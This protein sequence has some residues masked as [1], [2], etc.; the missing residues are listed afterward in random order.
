[1]YFYTMLLRLFSNYFYDFLTDTYWYFIILKKPK[2]KPV[3]IYKL[4]VS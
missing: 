3:I 1:M 4:F 2:S